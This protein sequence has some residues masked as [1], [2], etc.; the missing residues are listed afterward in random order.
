MVAAVGVVIAASVFMLLNPK[1][2]LGQTYLLTQN[3]W[4]GNAAA[5][6]VNATTNQSGWNKYAS[7]TGVTA[8]AGSITLPASQTNLSDTFTTTANEDVANTTANWNTSTGNIEMI[9]DPTTDLSSAINSYFP[10]DYYISTMVL[11][12]VRNVQYLYGADNN[13]DACVLV[14]YNI[15]TGAVTDLSSALNTAVSGCRGD[16]I[17]GQMVYYPA[18]GEIYGEAVNA[19]FTAGYFFKINTANDVI[20]DLSST[21]SPAIGSNAPRSLAMDTTNGVLY[22]S[23]Q[24]NAFG[25]FG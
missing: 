9:T 4:S 25:K 1:M 20:T 2:V 14:K 21:I 15:G 7:S 13:A 23:G 11:D 18:T 10:A 3:D 5:D 12:P 22:I 8:G 17:G 16:N 6:T 24:N 19:S